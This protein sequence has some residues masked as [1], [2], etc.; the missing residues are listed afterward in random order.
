MLILQ[1]FTWLLLKPLI[2][3]LFKFVDNLTGHN[4][5]TC[6][7]ISV[8]VIKSLLMHTQH[9]PA[10]P[11]RLVGWL[12]FASRLLQEI[13]F[14]ILNQDWNHIPTESGMYFGLMFFIPTYITSCFTILTHIAPH[15]PIK[16]SHFMSYHAMF[17]KP[18]QMSREEKSGD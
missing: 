10:E 9:F 8:P 15:L 11:L 2:S 14:R 18:T 5:S 4:R 1:Q 13:T 12:F 16:D 7:F 3:L 6:S 17:Q